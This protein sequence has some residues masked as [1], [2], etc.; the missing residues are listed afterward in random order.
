MSSLIQ[1]IGTRLLNWSFIQFIIK[2]F[3]GFFR[4]EGFKWQPHLALLI[5][6]SIALPINYQY[7]I[8]GWVLTD[9]YHEPSSVLL[10]TAFYTI[11]FL[12]T[13]ALVSFFI[14][15]KKKQPI[16]NWKYLTFGIIGIS[17]MSLDCSYYL[18]KYSKFMMSDNPLV[19][20][21]M[22]QCIGNLSSLVTIIIPLFI[23]YFSV[24][25]FKSEL[26]GFRLNG[27]KVT[28]YLWLFLLMIPLIYLASLQPDFLETYPAYNDRWEYQF[29]GV[30]Q[31]VTVGIFELCY[32]F[33]FLSVELFYRGFMVV[34]LSRFVG[35][36]AILPMVA[37]YCFL[38][39]GKPAGEAISSIFGGYILG[40]LAYRS[41]NIFGGLIAHLGVA[42]GMEFMAWI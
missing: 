32:G 13:S 14:K 33:D 25:H 42:W 16:R 39:F 7:D 35:K 34:A 1:S 2:N 36:E 5:F 27:A 38:H 28:P 24:K 40:V 15:D 41:R 37:V 18:M 21:W 9:H 8:Y 10:L 30:D 22:R 19:A 4:E 31:W 6:L 29:L 23:I 20:N 3:I 17:F 26:Y 11:A 12:F